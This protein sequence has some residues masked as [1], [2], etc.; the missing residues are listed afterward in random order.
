[1]RQTKP[2]YDNET[3]A[4]T[5]IPNLHRG[6][7][8]KLNVALLSVLN[9]EDAANWLD[10]QNEHSIIVDTFSDEDRVCWDRHQSCHI[11]YEWIESVIPYG[12]CEHCQAVLDLDTVEN[13]THQC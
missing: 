2:W 3:Q 13:G 8:I 11:P 12:R 4:W 9:D 5:E 6:C 7:E 10:Y 1:M